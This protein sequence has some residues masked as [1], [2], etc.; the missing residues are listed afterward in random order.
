MFFG[1]RQSFDSKLREWILNHVGENTLFMS[2]Y[3]AKQFENAKNI[4]ADDNYLAKAG[5]C[6]YCFIEDKP[7]DIDRANE[8]ILCHWNRKYQADL[9]LNLDKDLNGFKLCE[10]CDIVGSSH[11][12]ITIKRYTR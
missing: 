9:F 7:Y 6:D 3:S 4:V 11:K 5:L 12:K 10:S 1:R 8:I 2:K